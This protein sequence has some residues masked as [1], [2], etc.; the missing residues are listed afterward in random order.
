MHTRT[1]SY[2]REIRCGC[3]IVALPRFKHHRNLVHLLQI[4]GAM[5]NW[6]FK[7]L[8][9][10]QIRQRLDHQYL[11]ARDACGSGQK[12]FGSIVNSAALHELIVQS[13]PESRN[14]YEVLREDKPH[15]LYFDV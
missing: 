12:Q 8:V 15:L 9:A 3:S 1:W 11:I 7:K 6:H 10:E 14:Y 13:P 2:A 5:S 4:D